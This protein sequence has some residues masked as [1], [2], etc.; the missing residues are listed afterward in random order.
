MI[1][2]DRTPSVAPA[3]GTGRVQLSFTVEDK[4]A[5]PT[6]RTVRVPPGVS[7]FDSAS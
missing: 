4:E 5:P 6:Q 2:A 1:A 7:V 3:D